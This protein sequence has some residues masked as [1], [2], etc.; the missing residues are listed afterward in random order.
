V[1]R[2]KR[3]DKRIQGAAAR[4][5][6]QVQR[7]A[8]RFQNFNS[9]RQSFGW[10]DFT[11]CAA[12]LFEQ[13]FAGRIETGNWTFSDPAHRTASNLSAMSPECKFGYRRVSDA[14]QFMAQIY[15]G[16]M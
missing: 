2:L 8:I 4:A 15:C 6:N 1:R 16:A 7:A 10:Y 13:T 9:G 12:N 3:Q 14:D 11:I 5:S